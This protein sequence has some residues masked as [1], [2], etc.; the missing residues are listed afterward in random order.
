MINR[1]YRYI[2]LYLHRCLAKINPRLVRNIFF[3]T[4]LLQLILS[5]V[6]WSLYNSSE[7]KDSIPGLL[8]SASIAYY[9]SGS[10]SSN[11]LNSNKPYVNPKTLDPDYE[12]FKIDPIIQ[13]QQNIIKYNNNNDQDA[14]ELEENDEHI[15]DSS[16][17]WWDYIPALIYDNSNN[18]E[19]GS[20]LLRLYKLYEKM[21]FNTKPMWIDE[22]TLEN[23]L[24]IPV[25]ADKGSRV[26][27]IDDLELYDFD[28][29][30]TWSVY[31]DHMMRNADDTSSL[32]LP[33]S[34]YDW[35]DFHELNKLIALKE[36]KLSCNFFFEG[37]FDKETLDIIENEIGEP[38]FRNERDKYSLNRWYLFSRKLSTRHIFSVIS[39]HCSNMGI[40]DGKIVKP[41]FSTG[42][43]ITLLFDRVRTEV[44]QLQTRNALLTSERNPLSLTMVS[45]DGESFQIEVEQNERANVIESRLMHDFIGLQDTSKYDDNEEDMEYADLNSQLDPRG[46]VFDHERIWHNFLTNDTAKDKY[47][48]KIKETDPEIFKHDYI[49]LKPEDFEFDA[50]AKIEELEAIPKE[51]ISAHNLHYLNSLKTSVRTHPALAPKYFSEPGNIQQFKGMGHHRDKRFFN[52]DDLIDSHQEYFNR[53][54][55]MIRTFQ[56]F[57]YNNGILSWLGH[58]TLY[59]YIYNA[60]TFPW[61]ND[62]DLQLPI[63]HLN[64]LAQYFNQSL[65]LE[66]PRYGNGRYLVDV[67]DSITVRNNGNGKNNI[68]AR[69]IDVDTGLYI[70]LTG[71]SISDD[72]AKDSMRSYL[73]EQAKKSNYTYDRVLKNILPNP[74]DKF[75]EENNNLARLNIT[76]LQTYVKDHESDFGNDA[77]DAVKKLVKQETEELI[78]S[79]KLERGLNS[80]ERYE[81]HKKFQVYNC[82]N[83]HFV[84]L[85]IISPLVNTM[86]HGIP[87]LIPTKYITALQHEYSV[88]KP[89]GYS[90]FQGKTYLPDLRYWVKSKIVE[91][92]SN[93]KGWYPDEIYTPLEKTK[94]LND[95]DF[96]DIWTIL[97]NIKGSK[98]FKDGNIDLLANIY[99]SF[100]STS[101]RLRELEIQYAQN[102]S[103]SMKREYLSLLRSEVSPNLLSPGKDPVI[104]LHERTL[105]EQLSKEFNQTLIDK[106]ESAVQDKY[107]RK[108]WRSLNDLKYK[109]LDLFNVTLPE[110]SSIKS[111][112]ETYI[113]F[114]KLNTPDYFNDPNKKPNSLFA[115]DPVLEM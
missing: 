67:G 106:I 51:E 34:W 8:S 27:S 90:T 73:E 60:Q 102:I 41:K 25:G 70:D 31:L 33:F 82:R 39:N 77:K 30:L 98:E 28:P 42:L 23:F 65:I 22:Y 21:K 93:L 43:N 64:Y 72:V 86:Y 2:H 47:K 40:K 61:D 96:N 13:Q 101:Y 97:M 10:E 100:T 78:K 15:A 68:D 24:T 53:L 36:T 99:N 48:L 44:F 79:K 55:A 92:C 52:G 6:Y 32:K 49:H 105:Y 50:H 66:D 3:A 109:K 80:A 75:K 83:D 45:D 115:K 91:K 81:T 35:T 11:D 7:T 84:S 38:L 54:N 16:S 19:Q 95:I 4:I 57:T 29:R 114:N 56:K 111:D 89:Y 85:Q 76:Q 69:F 63:A 58:G 104:Y 110:E 12:Y 20:R 1:I 88:P 14:D 113:N 112:N 107:I 59:G 46:I 26:E 37:A 62:F 94:T 74:L 9:W 103:I 108:Y 71:L 5:L 17:S 18:E 87:T